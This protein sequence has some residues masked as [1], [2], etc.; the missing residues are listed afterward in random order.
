MSVVL[1]VVVEVTSA[2]E[3][4]ASPAKGLVTALEVVSAVTVT[5]VEAS[6]Y[7]PSLLVVSVK[8]RLAKGLVAPAVTVSEDTSTPEL[9][10]AREAKGETAWGESVCV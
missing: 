6:K 4:L 7:P 10:V 3:E 1:V 8:A 2:L 5:V 9:E